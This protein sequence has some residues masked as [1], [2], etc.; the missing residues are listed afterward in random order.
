ME[1]KAEPLVSGS[2]DVGLHP[3]RLGADIEENSAVSRG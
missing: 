1:I 2:L 3:Q